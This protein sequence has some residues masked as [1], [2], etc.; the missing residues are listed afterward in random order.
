MGRNGRLELARCFQR[1]ERL[2]S[3][4][5]FCVRAFS[6]STISV[7]SKLTLISLYS[8]DTGSGIPER[9]LE[10]IFRQ[11]EQ[12]STVGDQERSEESEASVGLGL[13]VVAR[14]VRSVLLSPLDETVD[15]IG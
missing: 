13:A 8:T 2:D 4:R 12:V 7:S 5:N 6:R 15:R 1:E 9:K 11:F 14:I 3:N 10:A